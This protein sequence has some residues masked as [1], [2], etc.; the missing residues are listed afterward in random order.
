MRKK[1]IIDGRVNNGTLTKIDEQLI[2]T[3]LITY[4]EEK[5]KITQELFDVLHQMG[6]VDD[7]D[8][9]FSIKIISQA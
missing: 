6:V 3:G 4:E 9:K 5:G 1:I 8:E 2:N 7:T